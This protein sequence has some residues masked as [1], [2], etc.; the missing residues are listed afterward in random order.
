M[1]KNDTTNHYDLDAFRDFLV[2]VLD[3]EEEVL[4]TGHQKITVL[5]VQIGFNRLFV[6]FRGKSYW[7][8][9]E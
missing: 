8:V 6:T 2:K 7:L 9:I 5:G 4:V 3:N 1:T